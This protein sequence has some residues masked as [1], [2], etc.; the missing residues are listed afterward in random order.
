VSTV[1]R[2]S[3]FDKQK[4]L[5][6]RIADCGMRWHWNNFS[7]VQENQQ[8]NI[9]NSFW[10]VLHVIG[11]AWLAT[12]RWRESVTAPL[13]FWPNW[14]RAEG[15]VRNGSVKIIS[16]RIVSGVGLR[17]GGPQTKQTA[18]FREKT[19]REKRVEFCWFEFSWVELSKQVDWVEMQT[20]YWRGG[21][22]CMPPSTTDRLVRSRQAEIAALLKIWSLRF[23][24]I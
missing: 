15:S 11:N 10:P 1:N 12:L 3:T 24:R 6:I 7:Q 22:C 4:N 9:I 17:S 14:E 20:V 8:Y 13:V 2:R 18:E 16:Y 19:S 21:T 5:S 23:R